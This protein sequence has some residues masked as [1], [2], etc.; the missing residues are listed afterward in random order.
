M[1]TEEYR[2][3]DSEVVRKIEQVYDTAVIFCLQ[4]KTFNSEV[5]CKAFEL[6]PY[7]CEELITTMLING[8]IGDISDDGEYRVSD[9]YNHSNYLL[10][11][12]L[13]KEEKVKEVTKP[14]I[15]LGRYFGFLALVVF[16]VSVY[17]LFRSPMS[18][19]IVIPLSLAIVSGVEKIGAVASSI[20]VIVVCGASIMWV[21]SASPIF[22]ERYEARVALEEYKDNERKA[23]IE[24]MNQVSFGEKRLK[25][26]LKDPSSADIRNSRLG[27]SGV[28]CGE[29]NAK[30]SF[31]A[32]TGYKNFIQ[33]GS[34][35]LIDDGSS[36]FTKEWNEMCR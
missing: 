12:E 9:N 2:S 21:N 17:F 34:T 20:G 25:N 32:F 23:R 14:T 22:G 36:E 16:V 13:K 35:T 28:T 15:K 8:V 5:L 1:V 11:E 30:N 18:L 10:A 4:R 26:S 33:I 19:F 3:I 27:K 31:G 7:T 24:E 29:V 6:D